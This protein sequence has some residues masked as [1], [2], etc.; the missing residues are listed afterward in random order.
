MRMVSLTLSVPQELRERMDM[1]SEI[2][3]SEVA[4]KAFN[5]KIS[6]MEFLEEFKSQSTMTEEDAVMLG[7][8]VNKGMAKR[9]KEFMENNK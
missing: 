1:Y 7:R 6:D 8:E 3:W 4:R 5:A 9:L 2:N